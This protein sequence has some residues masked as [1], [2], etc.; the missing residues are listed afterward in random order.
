MD[1]ARVIEHMR[2]VRETTPA[3]AAVPGA[4]A[5]KMVPSV[6]AVKR[7]KELEFGV[8]PHHKSEEKPTHLKKISKD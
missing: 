7:S 2:E 1:F 5:K 6:E 8:K 4:S 3:A